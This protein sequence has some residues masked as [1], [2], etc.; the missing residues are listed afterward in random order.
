MVFPMPRMAYLR[1]RFLRQAELCKLHWTACQLSNVLRWKWH[2]GACVTI[3]NGRSSP[4]GK[5]RKPMGRGLV[6][7]SRHW[8]AWASMCRAAR[9]ATPE[10]GTDES[11]CPAKVA[12]QVREIIMVTPTPGGEAQQADA[13]GRSACRC[14]SRIRPLSGAQAGVK[15]HWLLWHRGAFPAVDK[16]VGPGNA[17]M[18]AESPTS[19]VRPCRYHRHGRRA[20]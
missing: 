19:R 13:G 4:I 16:I 20:F 8:I 17:R 11:R 7:A 15:P 18:P 14:R 12:G 2:A 1:W 5:C 10:F 3:T 9:R 6:N